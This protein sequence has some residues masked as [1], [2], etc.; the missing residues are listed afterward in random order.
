[1][2]KYKLTVYRSKSVDCDDCDLNKTDCYK[3]LDDPKCNKHKIYKR[4]RGKK[5]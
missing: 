2:K 4:V 3:L 1:M 5:N